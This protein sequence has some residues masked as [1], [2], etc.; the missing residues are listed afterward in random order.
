MQAIRNPSPAT[1]GAAALFV[2][3][4]LTLAWLINRALRQARHAA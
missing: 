1:L 2:A 4:P 3:V